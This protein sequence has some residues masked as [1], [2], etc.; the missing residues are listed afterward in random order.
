[1]EDGEYSLAGFLGGWNAGNAFG[2]RGMLSHDDLD[3]PIL[4]VP[5][6]QIEILWRLEL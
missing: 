4:T 5:S 2:Y 3:Q 1:M 6:A